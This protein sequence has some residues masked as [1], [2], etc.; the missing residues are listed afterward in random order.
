M[1]AIILANIMG[2]LGDKSFIDAACVVQAP[3]KSWES[4]EQLNKALFGVYD[5]LLGK[6]MTDV[7]LEH[8]DQLKNVIEYDKIKDAKPSLL[9]L[10]E[11]IVANFYGFDDR[12]DYY[13]KAACYHRIP[14]ITKPTFFMNALDDPIIGE[15]TIDYE[16]FKNNENVVL[17]TT[18]HGGHLG[19]HTSIFHENGWFLEPVFG[20]LN[21][22]K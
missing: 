19:Y 16:I 10:D 20:F 17:G 9:N 6:Y 8:K 18:K 3:I 13:F 14:S 4:A 7:W 1:G 21:T 11:K 15:R 12:A 2:H 5:R 22:Y